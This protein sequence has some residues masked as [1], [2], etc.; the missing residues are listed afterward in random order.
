MK[1]KLF[2]LLVALCAASN[3]F[4]YDFQY[5]DLCYNITSSSDKIVEVTY[6]SHTSNPTNYMGL[7]SATIP[8]T[9]TYNGTTY[10]VTNIGN[11]AFE[12]CTGLISIT[13]PNSVTTIGQVAFLKCTGLTSITIPNSVTSIGKETFFGCTSLTSVTIGNSV[14]SIEGLAFGGCTSLTSI[15]IPNSVTSIGGGA[16]NGCTSL[17]SITIP[18]SVTTIGEYAF[19]GCTGLKKVIVLPAQ[20]PSIDKSAFGVCYYIDTVAVPKCYLEAYKSIQWGGFIKYQ[21]YAHKLSV[22]IESADSTLGTVT[23][24]TND[25]LMDCGQIIAATAVCHKDDYAF[26][27]W[28]DGNT[29]N[30]RTIVVDNEDISLTALF[31][32]VY[33]GACGEAAQW[34]YADGALRIT[35]TGAM[36]D[37]A[38]DKVPWRLFRDSI[39]QVSIAEGITSVGACSLTGLSRLINNHIAK[40]RYVYW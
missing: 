38:Q 2:S 34:Q 30:P 15:T 17:T 18:N 10:S 16:F 23:L 26:T 20:C 19:N 8:A 32:K 6:E 3:L 35:G 9:V 22:H 7:T 39:Q 21:F 31:A 4:A 12:G 40:Q 29:D 27:K 24:S 37:Y 25:T 1:T 28:S 11:S 5:G 36:Y 14:T 13:I 33:S